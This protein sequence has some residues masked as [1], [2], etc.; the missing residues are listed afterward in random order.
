[1][2]AIDFPNS[3]TTGQSFTVGEITWTWTGIVWK[4]IGTPTPGPAGPAGPAG[5]NGTNGVDGID[6]EPAMHPF[7]L[8]F[9]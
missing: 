9:S 2:A 3:P 8:A 4:S 7:M 5:A 1:M 6:G